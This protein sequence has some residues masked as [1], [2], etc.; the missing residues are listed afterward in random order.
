MKASSTVSLVQSD[1]DEEDG[2]DNSD[3]DDLNDR[4]QMGD[5]D[6]LPDRRR[7]GGTTP[8]E[9]RLSAGP[10]NVSTPS[11]TPSTFSK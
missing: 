6:Q 7:C 10:L 5:E 3:D 4:V 2:G 8:I 11:K 1:D 9:L